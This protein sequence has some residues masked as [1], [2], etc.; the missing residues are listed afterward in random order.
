VE[1]VDVEA[2]RVILDEIR[3]ALLADGGPASHAV[4]LA[5]LLA[6]VQFAV[7]K[8]R[9]SAGKDDIRLASQV[10]QLIPEIADHI[11]ARYNDL[12]RRLE[13]DAPWV[14]VPLGWE[15]NLLSPMGKSAH[16]PTHTQ[17]LAYLLD[18][19]R[20]HG[21]GVRVVREFFGLLGRLIPG[22]DTYERLAVDS[23]EGSEVLR[24]VQV[25]AEEI[26]ESPGREGRCDLWLELSDDDRTLILLIENK[27]EAT[28]HGNQL[29]AY[30]DAVWHYARRRRRLS[31]EAKLVFLTLDGRAPAQDYD[32]ALWLPVSYLQ[33]AA[34]LARA[35]RDAPE[36][37][38]TFL[39]LYTASILRLLGIPSE[40]AFPQRLRHLP[41]LSE[42]PDLGG[43]P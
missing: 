22:A 29:Q 7:E 4:D 16:E 35:T 9:A 14:L 28:E 18:P 23:P 11:A 12:R 10:D 2:S 24:C 13:A 15:L 3:Q 32:Q 40:G 39:N 43:L 27:V 26:V 20:E 19:R 6:E 1:V 5:G 25:R 21:L 31:F 42:F 8:D 41:Y 33:L 36:P 38:R 30:E 37:G 17:I 34:A